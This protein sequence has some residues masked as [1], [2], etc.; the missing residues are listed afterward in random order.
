MKQSFPQKMMAKIVKTLDPRFEKYR[1]KSMAEAE[2]ERKKDRD[3]SEGDLCS[4]FAQLEEHRD[5]LVF[6]V[7]HFIKKLVIINTHE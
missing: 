4:R 5:L 2:N 1:E 7:E 6:V 3:R